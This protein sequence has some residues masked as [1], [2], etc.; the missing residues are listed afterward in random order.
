MSGWARGSHEL[1]AQTAGGIRA[2][3][4]PVGRGGDLRL[5]PPSRAGRSNGTTRNEPRRWWRNFA[6]SSTAGALRLCTASKPSPAGDPAIRMALAVSHGSPDY[7]AF[8]ERSQKHR[9][10]PA[11][12]LSRVRGQSGNDYFFGAMAGEVRLQGQLVSRDRRRRTHF[13]SRRIFP[14]ARPW[15]CPPIRE[16]A[17]RRKAAVCDRRTAAGQRLPGEA[18]N[19]PLER[20]PCSIRIWRSGFSPAT[21]DRA[22]GT[23]CHSPQRLAPLI[24]QVQQQRQETGALIHWSADALDD[25]TVHAIPLTGQDNQ[26]LG[27]LL[28]GNSRRPYVGLRRHIRSAALLAGAAGILLAILF[29]GW[30]AGRVTRPVE[31]LAEAAREVAAGQLGRARFR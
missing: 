13:S 2:D 12:G 3:R 19:S 17:G 23:A 18:W 22:F 9:R 25:E 16:V 21:A 27:I 31:Q 29:T 7:G 1:P 11:A 20:G 30:A 14:T 15:V 8:R 28:V 5:F 24:Q 10:R 6:A 26:L 4:V